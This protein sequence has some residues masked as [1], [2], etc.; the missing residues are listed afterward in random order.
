MA[1]TPEQ[2]ALVKSTAPLLK[3]HGKAITTIFYQRM[4]T[5]RPELNNIFS[6][7]HQQEGAQQAA[8]AS[9]VMAYA[10]YID[11]L[12]RL[13]GAVDRIAQR[14][15]SLVVQP[16]QYAVIGQFLVAAFA[17]VL[18]DAV[19][20]PAVVDAWVA[21]YRQLA[22]VFIRRER[23]LYDE[24]DD[25]RGWRTFRVHGKEVEAEHVVSLYLQPV[26]GRL[27]LPR[28]RPGQ[29]VSARIRVPELD[30]LF[31]S[32][33]LSLS[34]APRDDME[35]YRV[36]VKRE[37]E[38]TT[39]TTTTTTMA[40]AGLVSSKLHDDYDVGHQLELSAPRG[41]F[42]LDDDKEAGKAAVVLIS[43]G[44]GANP[45]MSILQSLAN[46]STD[47]PVSWIHGAR[48]SGAMCFG[49][50]L[51]QITTRNAN[52]RPFIF[53]KTVASGDELGRDYHVEGRLSL[54][55]LEAEEGLLHLED[56]AAGYYICGRTN[57]M[58]QAREWL[59]ER[60]V[61]AERIH[62][63]LFSVGEVPMRPVGETEVG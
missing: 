14:H 56:D 36:S 37:E 23:Q 22:D 9:A 15:A 10:T 57:W 19:L 16:E 33:Q 55:R 53:L 46:S 59:K 50:E 27:P 25:W 26:D 21:A 51:R 62:L 18:G 38:T 28:Y 61:G 4:L 60:G 31:Q 17:E 6:L 42:F 7:R 3:Q 34:M 58:A 11:D 12:G 49:N 29:Y 5:A 20:T 32:R 35:V 43:L 39:T 44:V 30:G 1:L 52:V 63:E 48:H 24:F 13:T 2:V 47:R 8:L 41:E 40:M 54:D 45:V